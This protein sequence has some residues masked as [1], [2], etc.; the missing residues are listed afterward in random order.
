MGTIKVKT[1]KTKTPSNTTTA[2]NVRVARP[3]TDAKTTGVKVASSNVKTVNYNTKTAGS[4]AKTAGPNTKSAI[5]VK[6]NTMKLPFWRRLYFKPSTIV[7][8]VIVLIF[9]LFFLRVALWEHNYIDRMTGAVRETPIDNN[10]DLHIEDTGEEADRTEVT[11]TEIREYIVAAD[12]PRY[13]SIPTLG[14]HKSRIIEVGLLANSE[15]ATPRSIYD[16]GWYTGSVLPGTAGVSVMDGHGGAIG[17]GILGNLSG[18]N[19]QDPSIKP[20]QQITIEMG[21]GRIFN[22]T[23]SDVAVR[24]N[25]QEAN[26]YMETAFS[27]PDPSKG[28]LTVITCTGT[29]LLSSRTYSHR[30][31]VRAVLN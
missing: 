5:K 20:G 1:R 26:D 12:K 11:E 22:Y 10:A 27:A 28:S 8:S 29:Y 24:A 31:F 2:S 19:Y 9:A 13:F 16:I 7:L 6:D 25:G 14:I 21:D 30:L 15:M 3:A 4:S 18:R 23:V 17:V